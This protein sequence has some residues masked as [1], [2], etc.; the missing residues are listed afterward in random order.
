MR[1]PAKLF[2]SRMYCLGRNIGALGLEFLGQ[3]SSKELGMAQACIPREGG[4]CGEEG[5]RNE[6]RDSGSMGRNERVRSV[7]NTQE[8]YWKPMMNGP[9]GDELIRGNKR[10]LTLRPGAAGS[11]PLLS[12]TINASALSG[13]KPY[14]LE[15]DMCPTSPT[16]RLSIRC[17]VGF[18]PGSNL[19]LKGKKSGVRTQFPVRF[20]APVLSDEYTS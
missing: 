2:S 19:L 7:L 9:M 17:P 20:S 12:Y 18:A 10:T 8:S 13:R 3:S 15:R 6:G 14:G 4:F 16:R 11:H 1:I 5:V